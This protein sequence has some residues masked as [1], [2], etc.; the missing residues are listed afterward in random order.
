RF[1]NAPTG[2]LTGENQMFG[3]LGTMAT[4]TWQ[5]VAPNGDLLQLN[6]ASNP[7]LPGNGLWL[8][9]FGFDGSLGMPDQSQSIPLDHVTHAEIID[10][11]PDGVVVVID[12]HD[13]VFDLNT[14]TPR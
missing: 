2:T 8:Q 13:R 3:F 11:V 1:A 4:S 12:G 14:F 10:T 6:V 5:T 7:Q 9:Y